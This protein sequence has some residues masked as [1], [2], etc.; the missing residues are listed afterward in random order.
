MSRALFIAP[1]IPNSCLC[2]YIA[3]PPTRVHAFFINFCVLQIVE[4]LR[5]GMQYCLQ[6]ECNIMVPFTNIMK[7]SVA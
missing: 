7:N 2:T 4:F 1:H 3:T 5:T 6:L